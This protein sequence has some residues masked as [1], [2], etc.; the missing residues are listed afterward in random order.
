[1]GFRTRTLVRGVG[2]VIDM[3]FEV[4]LNR[5][6]FWANVVF[7][8]ELEDPE[9]TGFN[10]VLDLGCFISLVRIRVDGGLGCA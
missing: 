2:E 1:M 7:W 3:G 4:V 6:R 10:G 5:N 8:P 9:E